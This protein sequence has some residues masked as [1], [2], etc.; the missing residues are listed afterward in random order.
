MQFQFYLFIFIFCLVLRA[1]LDTGLPRGN[2]HEQDSQVPCKVPSLPNPTTRKGWPHPRGLR[3]LHQQ[4]G[5]FYF[6][7]EQIS[8]SA[9]RRDLRFFVLIRECVLI[10]LLS[11]ADCRFVYFPHNNRCL[12]YLHKSIE[13]LVMCVY[14]IN[15]EI[16]LLV[17]MLY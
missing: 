10:S 7:Q 9:V 14:F 12:L 3:P 13:N 2:R 6:P 1:F 11:Q 17:L 4:C 8:K 5:F 16:V 15:F